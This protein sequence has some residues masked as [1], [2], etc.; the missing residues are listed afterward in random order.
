MLPSVPCIFYHAKAQRREEVLA[1]PVILQSYFGDDASVTVIGNC[2]IGN[3]R[4]GHGLR[5]GL[6]PVGFRMILGAVA[7]ITV[8]P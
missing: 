3:C 6:V 1:Q 4:V 8:I 7:P 5:R 2:V